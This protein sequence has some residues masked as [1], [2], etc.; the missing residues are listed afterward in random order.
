M[1]ARAFARWPWGQSWEPGFR[2]GWPSR[3]CRR[4][5]GPGIQPQLLS[6]GQPDL[7]PSVT[8]QRGMATQAQGHD[9]SGDHRRPHLSHLGSYFT[10]S[11]GRTT[12]RG[13][14]HRVSVS[15][16]GSCCCRCYAPNTPMA[17]K[18]LHTRL[19]VTTRAYI[20][21]EPPQ[22]RSRIEKVL[23]GFPPPRISYSSTFMKG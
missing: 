21:T 10:R 18:T 3:T 20:H 12:L 16:S 22:T 13:L 5:T 17:F 19:N 6:P 9:H 7:P 1:R 2:G 11:A 15:A 23:P 8:R 14:T 4:G